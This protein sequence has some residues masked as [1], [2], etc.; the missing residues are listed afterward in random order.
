MTQ[1]SPG[2]Q[3]VPEQN[4]FVTESPLLIKLQ[5]RLQAEEYVGAHRLF[6]RARQSATRVLSFIAIFLL[7]VIVGM[8]LFLFI[9]SG[10]EESGLLVLLLPLLL[11]FLQR[12]VVTVSARHAYEKDPDLGESRR[13]WFFDDR[14]EVVSQKGRSVFFWPDVGGG[15]ENG[16]L[17]LL[18]CGMQMVVVPAGAVDPP[19]AA[20]LHN[21]LLAK[22]SSRFHFFSA[23][24]AYG[25]AD[26]PE[27]EFPVSPLH[28]A[29][30]AAEIPQDVHQFPPFVLDLPNRPAVNP[31]WAI[32][33]VFSVLFSLCLAVLLTAEWQESLF[34]GAFFWW[35]WGA[36]FVLLC[37]LTQLMFRISAKSALRAEP[38]LRITL[39]P[40][41]FGTDTG[42]NSLL[43]AW[44][45]VRVRE[46]D[47][48]FWI[49]GIGVLGRQ[50]KICK[51]EIPPEVFEELRRLLVRCCPNY[52]SS[53]G[54]IPR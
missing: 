38:R 19:A 37:G 49:G 12:T 33:I 46:T 39:I 16:E 35:C 48:A 6:L 24:Q 1:G 23:I 27:E 17:L 4:A 25:A 41:G 26:F 18:W 14:V 31:S 21:L 9:A 22:L 34:T 47:S 29:I 20:Y 2:R 51:K 8:V 53:S 7:A 15:A 42:R 44:E 3:D 32:T 50:L 30:S 5:V 36:F 43:T 52:R 54:V 40:T 10:G 11:P 28:A 13:I 45:S